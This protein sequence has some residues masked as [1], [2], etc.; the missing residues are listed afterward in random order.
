MNELSIIFPVLNEKENLEILIPEYLNLLVSLNLDNFELIIV[1]DNST[2][3]TKELISDIRKQVPNL[4]YLCRD[5]KK[6]LPMSIFEGIQISKFNTVMWLDADCSMRASAAK[7]LIFEMITNNYS[8]VI[9]S[10]F[11]ENGGQ[12]GKTKINSIFNQLYRVFLSEDSLLAIYLSMLFNKLLKLITGSKISDLTS[13]F[14]ILEKKCINQKK[15]IFQDAFYG[16]YFINLISFFE[17]NNFPIKEIGYYC[18]IRKYG[19]SKTS[20]NY[21]NLIKLS[22]YYFKAA[23]KFKLSK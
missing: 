9:G 17:K 20:N 11:V 15:E 6:S 19:K 4:I 23:Y 2:D 14:V 18:E 1:D 10:R 5:S 21:F 13:G 7:N 12:K 16:D 3:G 22:K 8:A